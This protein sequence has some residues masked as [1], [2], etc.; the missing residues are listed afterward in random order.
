VS[1]RVLVLVVLFASAAFAAPGAQTRQDA[2]DRPVF[3][4]GVSLVQLDA[5]VTDRKGRHVTD[6][7]PDEFEIYQDGRR[8]P[9]TAAVYVEVDDRFVPTPYPTDDGATSSGEIVRSPDARRTIAIV[10]DDLRMGFVSIAHAR[11]ALRKFATTF[12]R[13]DDLVGLLTTSG[14]PGTSVRFSYSRPELTMAIG[15][16]RFSM[17]GLQAA[18][19]LDPVDGFGGDSITGYRE[20]SFAVGALGRIEAMIGLLREQPGRKAVVLVS[21]GFSMFGPGNDNTGIEYAMH[22]LVDRANRA[23]VVIYAIDPRGLVVTGLTA[24]DS[25]SAMSAH[26]VG[27]LASERAAALRET[28]NGLRYI[29]GETGGFAVVDDN[30]LAAGLR[31]VLDD[32]QGYYLIGYQPEPGTFGTDTSGRFRKVKLR[33]TRKDVRVRT[34]AGFYGVRTE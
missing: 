2:P 25:T 16:L 4:L 27:M 22:H 15:R 20:E 7:T 29:A 34:R 12:L 11:T 32:Q 28:Q 33:V 24:A 17:F 3:R 5:V 1:R 31:R 26:R 21:E 6:L 30:D 9:V 23:G 19:I 10:V 18:S 14:Q 8:Q 13:G